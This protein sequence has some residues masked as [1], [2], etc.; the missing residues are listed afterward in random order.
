MRFNHSGLVV[1]VTVTLAVSGLAVP[2]AA[3]GPR[4]A[5]QLPFRCGEVW[6]AATRQDHR[7]VEKIDF[8]KVGGGTNDSPVLASYRG[9][10]AATG[11]EVGG[12]GYFVAVDHGDGWKTEYFHLIR[13]AIVKEGDKVSTG[14][15]LGHVGS[16][17]DSSG[18]HLHYEQRRDNVIVR[19]HFD[20][21]QTTVAPGKPQTITSRNCGGPGASVAE[22]PAEPPAAEVKADTTPKR[23]VAGD[24]DGDGRTDMALFRPGDGTWYILPSGGGE[25]QA[26]P[27]GLASDLP[28]PGDYDG[29]RK[30]DLAVFRPGEGRW[31]ILLTGSRR[32]QV[33]PHGTATD[34]PVPADYDGDAVTDLAFFRPAEGRWY[35]MPSAGSR[36]QIHAHGQGT[37]KLVPGDYDGDGKADPAFFRPGDGSWH[38][39]P[40]SG[41]IEQVYPF[42]FAGDGIVPGDYDGDGKAD[43]AVFRPSEGNWYIRPSSGGAERIQKYG[44]ATDIPVPGDY[45]GDGRTDLAVFRPSEGK[46]YVLPSGGSPEQTRSYPHGDGIPTPLSVQTG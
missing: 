9:R 21:V 31:Y 2:A 39:L 37:D 28:A 25:Q 46:L 17:G 22:A 43:P 14:Q 26:V 13:P 41:G 35:I 16:T 5:F 44:F 30:L 18:P 33:L 23:F 3:A 45:D 6:E 7:P 40:S 34:V 29:D 1:A 24:R 11:Y 4:P 32:Q 38:I 27:Y 36:L 42:G 20:G 12:A 19:S 8:V 10:V 15:Q